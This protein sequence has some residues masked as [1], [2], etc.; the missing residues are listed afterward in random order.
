MPVRLD[1]DIKFAANDASGLQFALKWRLMNVSRAVST[2]YERQAPL[3]E[4]GV[5]S[6]PYYSLLPDET[7]P[8]RTRL[9]VNYQTI[10]RFFPLDNVSRRRS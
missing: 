5:R 2:A 7:R 8:G 6:G 3:D 1:G 4:R 9:G 10:R